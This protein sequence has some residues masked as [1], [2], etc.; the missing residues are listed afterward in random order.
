MKEAIYTFL[1][2]CISLSWSCNYFGDS[3]ESVQKKLEYIESIAGENQ[4]QFVIDKSDLEYLFAEKFDKLST[5][6]SSSI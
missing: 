5:H 6:L 1:L 3:K 2:C 4:N